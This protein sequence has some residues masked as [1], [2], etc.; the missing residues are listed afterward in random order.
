MHEWVLMNIQSN[1]AF[2]GIISLLIVLNDL[3]LS[4][5]NLAAISIRFMNS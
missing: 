5:Y 4:P 2:F 1:Q 3:L